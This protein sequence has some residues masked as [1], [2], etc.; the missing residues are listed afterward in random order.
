MLNT[1]RDDDYTTSLGRLF[2]CL[3]TLSEK[4]FF[5]ISN[6]SLPWSYHCYLGEELGLHLATTSFQAVVE[7]NEVSPEP[8][9]L[10][11]EQ[12]Q[13]PQP[14]PIRFVLQTLHQ[15]GHSPKK[16]S[17]VRFLAEFAVQSPLAKISKETNSSQ[18]K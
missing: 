8:P 14:I 18:I 4:K 2:Q 16:I 5:L 17:A 15:L 10:Q 1:S 7:S 9:L 3:T 11:T 6:L 12:S 13:F